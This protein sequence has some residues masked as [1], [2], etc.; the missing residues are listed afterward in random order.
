MACFGEFWFRKFGDCKV[1]VTREDNAA[2]VLLRLEH[3]NRDTHEVEI[4]NLGSSAL[5][6]GVEWT[7]VPAV[8]DEFFLT[9]RRDDPTKPASAHIVIQVRDQVLFDASCT[10]NGEAVSGQWK[11]I[12]FRS[13]A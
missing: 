8:T 12:C 5:E 11:I 4:E 3:R 9:I 2:N 1:T 10:S 13:A 6:K 7:L